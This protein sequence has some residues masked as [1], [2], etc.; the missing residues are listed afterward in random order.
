M[1]PALRGPA[2]DTMPVRIALID[3]HL[4][5]REGLRALIQAH[6]DLAVVAEGGDGREVY[7]LFEAATPGVAVVDIA[8]NGSSGI[9]VAQEI[10]RRWPQCRVLMLTMHTA[11]D[12]AIRA[13]A[14]GA[15]GYALKEQ[16]ATE[17]LDAIRSVAAGQRYLAPSLP[18][19]V[20]AGDGARTQ[21]DELTAREREVFDLILQSRSNR[22]ISAYLHISVKTVE[23]HRAAINR[24]LGA[25]STADLVRIAARLGLFPA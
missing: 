6:S 18:T 15:S 8:L 22:D 25:H 14:A 19:S 13:F 17:V 9:T 4:I 1:D 10:T 11:P 23:T 20:L 24:K 16:S 12:Y 5:F 7:P 21:L 3:D 2:F